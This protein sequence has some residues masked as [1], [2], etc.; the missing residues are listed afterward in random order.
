MKKKISILLL[1]LISMLIFA[2]ASC[3]RPI[4]DGL[5]SD[6]ISQ[7]EELME[8]DYV[9]DRSNGTVVITGIGTNKSANVT[10]PEEIEGYKVTQIAAN[11]FQDC[12]FQQISLPA[13][14]ESI[15]RAAF[16]NCVNLYAV[17][18]F[19]KTQVTKI[20][21]ET[22]YNCTKLYS[23][24]LPQTLT[25][26]GRNAFQNCGLTEFVLPDKLE[27]IEDYAFASCWYMNI[28]KLPDSLTIIG[29]SAFDN[30][31]SI[32]KINIPSSVERIE[33]YAFFACLNLQELILNDGLKY[34]DERAFCNCTSLL[35]VSIPST[36]YSVGKEAFWLCSTLTYVYIN[37]GVQKIDDVAFADTNISEVY[38]P[39]SV[40]IIGALAFYSTSLKNMSVD[41]NNPTYYSQNGSIYSK[42]DISIVRYPSVVQ[43]SSFTIPDGTKK[44]ETLAF[45]ATTLQT[46]NIPRSVEELGGRIFMF[47]S[48][49]NS[50]NYDGTVEEWFSIKKAED[51][52]DE[53][54]DYTIYCT[55]G[56]IAKDG[57]VTYK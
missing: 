18:N 7:K 37:D 15:G 33:K 45:A 21:S 13:S 36:V 46:I 26:I 51:W 11:A 19:D 28:D 16:Y 2:L 56:Q 22:F 27:V 30:C 25:L 32:T 6:S 8:L 14:L 48:S 17:K 41:I 24:K 49:L 50:I 20:L 55:N 29:E 10:I 5:G 44:I 57:T 42:K 34:I 53:T 54:I 40:N 23:I 31:H 4:S 3:D 43:E 12:T 35:S 38:V 47:S 9:I 52:D 39:Q 1:I